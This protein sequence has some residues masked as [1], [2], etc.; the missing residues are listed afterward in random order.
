MSVRPAVNRDA[1]R[2][3][4]VVRQ[5]FQT[6]YSL[7]PGEIDA[8]VEEEF[9]G[10]TISEHVQADD[11]RLFVAEDDDEVV[12]VA[13]TEITDDQTGELR[14]LHVEPGAR[15][16]GVGTEL[17]KQ[18]TAQLRERAAEP[19]NALVLAANEEGNQFFE[20]FEFERAVTDQREI[21]DQD[22]EVDVFTDTPEE[23][24]DETIPTEDAEQ[25]VPAD[26]EI[27]V[28]GETRYVDTDEEVPGDDGPFYVVYDDAAHGTR[29]GFYCSN[30][31]TF[32]G[33]VDG[34]GKIVCEE[35]G[36][37][38]RPDEWDASYL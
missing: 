33:S 28:E 20:Q 1:E 3:Q 18:A 19:V 29:Y 24:E 13:E 10:E 15:G 4:E 17:F 12:G 2:I 34:Q 9:D 30:S 38:H 7:S 11:D 26:G 25:S 37:E 35:C 27:V 36:N 5:S 6:S 21:A 8:I 22:L 16:Q 14:W 23:F 32:T 31:G